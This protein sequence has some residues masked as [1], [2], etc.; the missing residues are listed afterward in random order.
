M[1]RENKLELTH[2]QGRMGTR[3]LMFRKPFA[4][5][6]LIQPG[7]S[8][9]SN[10]AYHWNQFLG[11]DTSWPGE[12]MSRGPLGKE[13]GPGAKPS[14]TP[15]LSALIWDPFT[16]PS[17][18]WSG[19]LSSFSSST[20]W[21]SCTTNG[22]WAIFAPAISGTRRNVREAQTPTLACL[23][24]GPTGSF[25]L[26]KESTSSV[27]ESGRRHDMESGEVEQ[28]SCPVFSPSFLASMLRASW[29]PGGAKSAETQTLTTPFSC[30][31]ASPPARIPSL[32][33]H[34]GG[35]TQPKIRRQVMTAAL[36]FR[37]Q[38]WRR[39]RWSLDM[40]FFP[41]PFAST[42]WVPSSGRSSVLLKTSEER[43][44]YSKERKQNWR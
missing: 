24:W 14:P 37:E 30:S 41:G 13:V 2:W 29:L 18:G 8:C 7:R 1:Q 10:T 12:A 21:C 27:A 43:D 26:P 9:C 36:L 23:F 4:V 19:S 17:S 5:Q 3:L 40:A 11:S 31:P 28:W 44:Y 32:G 42:R 38:F 39:R 25:S 22:T 35:T 34:F 20:T 16:S 6:G 15:A 33:F